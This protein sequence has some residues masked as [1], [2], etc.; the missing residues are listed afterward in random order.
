MC[1]R[2]RR[3][4]WSGRDERAGPGCAVARGRCLDSLAAYA[5]PGPSPAAGSLD[6][7]RTSDSM[8]PTPAIWPNS[9]GPEPV[10]RDCP[11]VA[12]SGRPDRLGQVGA[13]PPADRAGQ[14][15]PSSPAHGLAMRDTEPEPWRVESAEVPGRVVHGART[16]SCPPWSAVRTTESD[17]HKE[18]FVYIGIGTLILV[19]ILLI[20][21]L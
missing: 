13:G 7:D 17:L 14:D 6:R 12:A 16:P 2:Q 20:I 3:A 21:L 11:Q 10:E 8:R 4:R 1:R 19:V 15:R 5:T 9:R 18:L